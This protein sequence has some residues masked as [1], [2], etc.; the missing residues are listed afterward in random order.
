[1]TQ[2]VE[3]KGVEVAG[4]TCDLGVVF[5]EELSEAKVDFRPGLDKMEDLG[6]YAADRILQ[7]SNLEFSSKEDAEK[8]VQN[9]INLN[10]AH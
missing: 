8:W 10:I 5:R 7:G 2:V 9:A 3:I 6:A 4:Q 1:M